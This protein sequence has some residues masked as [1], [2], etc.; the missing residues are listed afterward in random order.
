MDV[1]VLSTLAGTVQILAV[2]TKGPGSLG[3]GIKQENY[4]SPTYVVMGK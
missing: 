4:P 3:V 1:K 2:V